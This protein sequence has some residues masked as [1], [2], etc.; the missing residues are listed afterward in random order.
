MTRPS[1]AVTLLPWPGDSSF[2]TP[3]SCWVL[4][5][6]DFRGSSCRVG[7]STQQVP[8]LHLAGSGLSPPRP[9]LPR[10]AFPGAP[11]CPSHHTA[12]ASPWRHHLLIFHLN[13]YAVRAHE[14][15]PSWGSTSPVPCPQHSPPPQPRGCSSLG[16][17]GSGQATAHNLRQRAFPVLLRTQSWVPG[18]QEGRAHVLQAPSLL[19]PA[20]TI[21]ARS[22]GA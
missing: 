7:G 22:V 12:L 18:V 3:T 13:R 5:S 2:L 6:K 19:W 20:G 17:A 4:V 10:S 9:R 15:A 21:P 1:T 11:A 14:Q 8:V 16:Q